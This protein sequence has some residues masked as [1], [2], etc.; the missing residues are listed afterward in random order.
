MLPASAIWKQR[1][2]SRFLSSPD[3]SQLVKKLSA[4]SVHSNDA[5]FLGN[6]REGDAPETKC[7][8]VVVALCEVQVGGGNQEVQVLVHG[9]DVE[10]H[11]VV[12]TQ[13]LE[14]GME[15]EEVY[16]RGVWPLLDK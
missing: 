5:Y 2:S 8:S 10:E 12:N 6:K 15:D 11:G 4:G 3:P 14:V 9:R 7:L 1:T 13:F 16:G